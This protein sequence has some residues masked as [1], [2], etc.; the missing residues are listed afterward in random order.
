MYRALPLARKASSNGAAVVVRV[1][2]RRLVTEATEATSSSSA[3]AAP[4][5]KKRLLP[6]IIFYTT[7]ATTTFYVGS[8]FVAFNNHSYHAFFQQNIPLAPTVL[9]YGE[10]H[11]WDILTIADV[12]VNTYDGVTGAYAYVRKQ[13]GYAN[14]PPVK[15]P[16]TKPTASTTAQS[17]ASGGLNPAESRTRVQKAVD[18][19]KTDVKASSDKV[20]D[21]GGKAA[22]IARHRANQFSEGVEDLIRKA[23]AALQGKPLDAQPEATTTPDQPSPAV[24]DALGPQH[25]AAEAQAQAEKDEPVP[26][27]VYNAPLPLG[28]E[29]PPGFTRPAPPKPPKPLAPGEPLPLVA[30]AVAELHSSEPVL[31]HLAGTIDSLASFLNANPAAATK[32]RDVLDVAKGDLSAL[33]QSFERVREEEKA[34]LEQTLDEQTREYT[35][36]LLELELQAQDKLENQ[37]T[38]FRAFLD[39]EKARF[40]RAYQEKL[41]QELRTQ[42]EIINDRLKEEVVAQGIELQ[43][44]WIREVKVRVEEERGGR[45][46]K[47]DELAANLKRLERVALDNSSYLDAN[48][49]LH[50][51]WSALRAVGSTLD[52]PARRPFRDELRVLRH[53]AA[54]RD[55]AVAAAALDA[56]DASS[57]PD[58]GVEP[59]ADL[60]AWFS[61]R[62]APAVARVA[63]VP[64]ADAGVLAHAA[65]HVLSTLAFRRAGAAGGSDVL[66]VLARAEHALAEKDLDGAAREVNQ[67]RGTPRALVQD[68]LAAARRRLEVQQALEVVQAQATLA[69]LLVAQG[70]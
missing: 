54:A 47:L 53:A 46:A 26:K 21:Q 50:A 52:A 11:G 32:A 70:Q 25:N 56:L 64:D 1:S 23:E 7:A 29:P 8:A 9:Q 57:A 2:R 43:R 10:D 38:D 61:T 6:R 41:E 60:T 12:V 31:T 35:L 34:R 48:L 22:A 68:W 4:I 30:P 55:D 69:S 58:V 40:A 51:L 63:L 15:P 14:E 44:R 24:P 59:L 5:K 39:G 18:A 20:Y 37:E 62:V 16:Q 3:T 19:L 42:S 17:K 36:Q 28:H 33:A 65:S 13:L 66:S 45:L 49:R 27:N 67:L